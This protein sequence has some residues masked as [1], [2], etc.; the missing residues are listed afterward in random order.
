MHLRWPFIDAHD[1]GFRGHELQRHL[2]GHGHGAK[3]LD[4]VIHHLIDHLGR[5]HLGH[6]CGL[7]H[8]LAVVET[9]RSVMHHQARGMDLGRCVH[10]PPLHGLPVCR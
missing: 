4:G 10:D 2:L 7:A 8:V 3:R 9:G 1:T 6:G 5:E